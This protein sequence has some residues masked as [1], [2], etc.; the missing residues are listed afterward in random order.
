MAEDNSNPGTSGSGS[1]DTSGSGDDG[2][3]AAALIDKL[4]REKINWQ[5]KAS[6]LETR[7]KDLET[8]KQDDPNSKELV[9]KLSSE[10]QTLAAR[11]RESEEKDTKRRKAGAIQDELLKLGLEPKFQSDVLRLVDLAEVV[12]DPETQT[13]VGATDAAK[14]VFEKYKTLGFFKV[15]QKKINHQAAGNAR[16]Q[17]HDLDLKD[18]KLTVAKVR[19]YWKSKRQT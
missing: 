13:V 11:L 12:V 6:E 3:A 4:K 18:P 14:K 15:D 7:L 17:L 8:K 19:E 2:A 10:N 9:Q 1:K 16:P 5:T